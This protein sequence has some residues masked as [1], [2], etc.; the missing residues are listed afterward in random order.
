MRA[1]AAARLTPI[2]NRLAEDQDRGRRAT[3]P[4]TAPTMHP[5][6]I[7]AKTARA[8]ARLPLLGT[9]SEI[10]T[11]ERLAGKLI[12]DRHHGCALQRTIRVRPYPVPL[13]CRPDLTLA[14]SGS[15][16]RLTQPLPTVGIT[17]S[18]CRI[19][20]TRD[21]YASIGRPALPLAPTGRQRHA[22][23]TTHA[24]IAGERIFI[25]RANATCNRWASVR[26][27]ARSTDL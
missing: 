27:P 15:I 19:S 20:P 18:T 3:D 9:D 7:A 22:A 12:A 10:L 2:A 4:M 11:P 25:E 14:A 6:P 17:T 21:S 13:I 1:A 26:I 24:H 8:R 23:V 16:P 5:R